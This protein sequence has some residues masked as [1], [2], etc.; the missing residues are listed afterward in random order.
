MKFRIPNKT[1]YVTMSQVVKMYRDEVAKYGK[2]NVTLTFGCDSQRI[3]R[4]FRFVN[5]I[6]IRRKSKGARC[7]YR[8]MYHDVKE[9]PGI[10]VRML[11]ETEYSLEAATEFVRSLDIDEQAQVEFKSGTSIHLDMNED[12]RY[13]SNGALKAA[14][15]WVT[16]MGFHAVT[17]PNAIVSSTVADRFAIGKDV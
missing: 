3:Q 13:A 11:K 1:G 2:D 14:V 12:E 4:R 5:V 15:G 17:K 9:F 6:V 16:G 8:K 10:V 7:L